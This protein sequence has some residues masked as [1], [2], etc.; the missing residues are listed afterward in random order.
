MSNEESGAAASIPL[1]RDAILRRVALS[2]VQ[3]VV[4]FWLYR[5]AR[6]EAWPATNQGLIAALA[7]CALLLPLTWYVI[8]GLGARGQ[9]LALIAAIAA[10]LLLF[11]WHHGARATVVPVRAGHA[12]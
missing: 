4:L 6:L 11:G 9:R 3:G 8:D 10:A 1:S 5:A 2:L 7:T 12:R